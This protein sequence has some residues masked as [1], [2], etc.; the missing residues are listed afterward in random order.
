[1]PPP[2]PH[3]EQYANVYLAQILQA[4]GIPAEAEVSGRADRKHPDIF[5]KLSDL[6]IVLE[7]E[8]ANRRGAAKD[9]DAR[10][11]NDSPPRIIGA[12]SYSP[13]F[14]TDFARA[15]K[16]DAPLDFAFK[17]AG[18]GAGGWQA[19]WRTGTIYDLA[20]LLRRPHA[21]GRP[22]HDEVQ[23]AVAD[24]RGVLKSFVN[25]SCD[26]PGANYE[27]AKLLQASFAGGGQRTGSGG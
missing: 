1:M 27:I 3:V 11:K 5:I 8:Y 20:Q 2:P 19:R 17:R 12:I 24:I 26:K 22:L 25:R 4:L 10:L 6:D 16:A 13:W 18:D 9:A 15:V 21:I 14:K 23:E 7:A